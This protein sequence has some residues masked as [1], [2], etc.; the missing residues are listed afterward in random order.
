M[1]AKCAQAPATTA[2]A[3]VETRPMRVAPLYTMK[4]NWLVVEVTAGP[5]NAAMLL[6][7]AATPK[8]KNLE[9]GKTERR[10]VQFE[11][12]I[13]S[14]RALAGRASR[15]RQPVNTLALWKNYGAA[16]PLFAPLVRGW[17]VRPRE[18]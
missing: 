5:T 13:L 14:C 17:R 3:D 8:S 15:S 18:E 10:V 1:T 2:A 11:R 9:C 16:D 4:L 6:D 7:A 12:G